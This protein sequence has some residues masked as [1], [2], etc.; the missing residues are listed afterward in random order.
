MLLTYGKSRP[1]KTSKVLSF[2]STGK[3]SPLSNKN[4]SAT[5]AIGTYRY[6]PVLA[7]FD[8]TTTEG[9][10][11]NDL[12]KVHIRCG[13]TDRLLQGEIT[14][15]VVLRYKYRQPPQSFS[16]FLRTAKSAFRHFTDILSYCTT[17]YT[18]RVVSA[19]ILFPY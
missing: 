17:L 3:P 13:Q 5:E 11:Y 8:L 9:G 14:V 18:S 6:V 10:Y 2:V 7:Y 19:D 16:N 15:S 4:I 1:D 12:M